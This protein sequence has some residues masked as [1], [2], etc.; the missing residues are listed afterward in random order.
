MM[1][2]ILKKN[3]NDYQLMKDE[4]NNC[5]Y[6]CQSCCDCCICKCQGKYDDNSNFMSNTNIIVLLFGF[7][8]NT[9]Y[10]VDWISVGLYVIFM[11]LTYIKH[12]CMYNCCNIKKRCCVYSYNIILV[13]LPFGNVMLMAV[14]RQ[15]FR[16]QL[17]EN[18]TDNYYY[19]FNMNTPVNIDTDNK[20]NFVELTTIIGLYVL[21]VFDGVY[22]KKLENNKHRSIYL[23]S[24][25]ALVIILE[26]LVHSILIHKEDIVDNQVLTNFSVVSL[27]FKVFGYVML[28]LLVVFRR[29]LINRCFIIYLMALCSIF[30]IT[31]GITIA[32][33]FVIGCSQIGHFNKIFILISLIMCVIVFNITPNVVK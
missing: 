33:I 20:L 32:F 24:L 28:M 13:L 31:F 2:N 1:W 16:N 5:C 15:H 4:V 23:F 6:G 7:L 22:H 12:G 26:T 30:I 27:I 11:M 14:F 21:I 17:Y 18:L 8:F 29:P 25:I 9:Y 3:G 10:W 19:Y